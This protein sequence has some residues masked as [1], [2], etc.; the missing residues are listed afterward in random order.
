M[1]F[2]SMVSVVLA[3]LVTLHGNDPRQLSWTWH[4]S[5]AAPYHTTR[6]DVAIVDICMVVLGSI[7]LF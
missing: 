1:L 3:G 4:D 7:A 5:C 2:T 6:E